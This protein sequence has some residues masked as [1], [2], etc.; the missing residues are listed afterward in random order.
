MH[1][2]LPEIIQGGMGIGVSNWRLARAVS[3]HGQ[4]GV[5]SG[6]AIDTVLV[7]RLQRGDRGGHMRRALSRFPWQGIAQRVLDAYYVPGGVPAHTPFRCVP[8]LTVEMAPTSAEL[9]V[10]ANYCEVFLA[11]EGHH[12]LVGIN[13]LEKVQLPTLPSLL[14]AMMAGVDV[15]I[16]GGGI[17]LAIPGAIDGLM[18][19]EPIELAIDVEDDDSGAR[20]VHRFDPGSIAEHA[21]PDLARPTFLG[22]ISSDVVGKALLRRASG[23]VDGFVVE[24]HSAGGHNAPPRRNRAAGDGLPA[25]GTKDEPNLAR[26]AALG[27]PFWLGG[28]YGTPHGLDEARAAGA[29]GVQVGTAFAYCAESAIAPEIKRQVLARCAN[30]GIDVRT[31]FLASP[32]GYPFKLVSV[33]GAIAGLPDD[34]PRRRICDLGYLRTA[35]RQDDGTL[36]YRCPAEP[37]ARYV[38]KGGDPAATEGRQC[39]CNGLLATVGLGQVRP[40]SIEPPMVTSGQDL[41]GIAHLTATHPD[42]YSATDVLDYL[43]S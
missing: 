3:S 16:M 23:V 2:P 34:P 29:C 24:H 39:L 31:D 30:K 4:L 5:V 14:G 35:Y 26:I 18:A 19:W 21:M 12:N 13:Y 36:G 43:L 8:M 6:T 9:L 27:R 33:D 42:G 10:A 15:I 37:V 28:G 25:F 17:P 40:E 11:K 38:A 1:H 7:R 32:T 20:C 22:I 41:S